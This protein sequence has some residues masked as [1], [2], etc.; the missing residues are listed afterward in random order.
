MGFIRIELSLFCVLF[1]ERSRGSSESGNLYHCQIL[2][3][4]KYL[5]IFL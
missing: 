3:T 1:A 5:N 2:E 4:N